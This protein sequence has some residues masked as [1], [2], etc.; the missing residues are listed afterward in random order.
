MS[1]RSWRT[2]GARALTVLGALLLVVS[3]AANFVERQALDTSEFEETARQLITDEEIQA[4]VA[5]TV[6]DELF[7]NVDVQA[8]LEERL[9][10]DQQGLAG[11]IAGALRPVTERLAVRLLEGPRFQEVWVQ[12]VGGAQMQI[13]RV[14]D[15][16][17]RF[18]ETDQGVVAV[19][20]RPLLAELTG[21]LALGERLEERLPP[22]AGLI[23][24]FET[25]QLESAQTLT[26]VLRFVAAWI[27][28]LALAAWIGAVYLAGDRRRELRAIAI[29][30]V[31]VGLVLLA[32]RRLAGS[33]IV[34]E[35]AASEAREGAVES[36]WAI[37]TRLLADAA[38]AAIAV[39]LVAIVGVWLFGPSRR[40]T[41]AREALAPH[42]ARPVLTYGVAA[43]AFVA[44]FLWG[45]I[46]YVQRPLV[47]VAFAVA[48]ALG[49]E[50]LRRKAA[51][52]FPDAT[53][54]TRP[55]SDP[56]HA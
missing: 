33:Y 26:R 39:G 23:T 56:G 38:W 41:A 13:V 16:E 32:I 43:G 14:L 15:D 17:A 42:L 36:I 34:D 11:P 44:L 24:L 19:D 37:V 48:A 27:W 54:E 9:P 8:A 1:R 46:S 10:P 20:L 55:A 40:G 7:A 12:A 30:F 49:I 4:T 22:D 51:R 6:T 28:V 31:V 18:L 21:Q 3:I 25:E 5:A 47:I 35:L 45:P 29:A 53:A 52:E 2:I 50:A